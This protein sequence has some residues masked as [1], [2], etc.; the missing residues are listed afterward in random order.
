MNLEVYTDRR[1]LE[2]ETL[3]PLGVLKPGASATHKE[4]W[5]LFRGVP[6]CASEGDVV[7]HV[8]PIMKKLLA[9]RA[10]SG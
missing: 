10:R 2:L 4:C 7:K 9:G 1:I 6:A 3:A 8:M 5:H